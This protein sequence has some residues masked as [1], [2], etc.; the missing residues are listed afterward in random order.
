MLHESSQALPMQSA[1]QSLLSRL[2]ASG[3]A[4]ERGLMVLPRRPRWPECRTSWV[5]AGGR[6]SASEAGASP[7][8]S[9]HGQRHGPPY[10]G[11]PISLGGSRRPAGPVYTHQRLSLPLPFQRDGCLII[12]MTFLSHK[13]CLPAEERFQPCVC[14]ASYSQDLSSVRT[15]DTSCRH[16]LI[17]KAL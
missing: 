3:P 14:P 16:W 6:G 17:H 9:P 10:H 15:T 11:R 2:S 13:L 7:L 12:L 4:P 8:R 1:N 5:W